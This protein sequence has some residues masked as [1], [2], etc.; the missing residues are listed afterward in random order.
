VVSSIKRMAAAPYKDSQSWEEA[1]ECPLETPQDTICSPPI[2]TLQQRTSA[3]KEVQY[4]FRLEAPL[5]CSQS[6]ELPLKKL[7]RRKKARVQKESER[8]VSL[9]LDESCEFLVTKVSRQDLR[10]FGAK[11]LGNRELEKII[12]KDSRQPPERTCFYR[13]ELPDI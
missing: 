6:K 5:G 2:G 8:Q 9:P 10:K 13:D 3:D 1:V 4:S 7:K 11:V 12:L